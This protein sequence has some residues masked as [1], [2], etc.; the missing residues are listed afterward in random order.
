MGYTPFFYV[1]GVGLSTLEQKLTEML[2]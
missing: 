1:L 2:T